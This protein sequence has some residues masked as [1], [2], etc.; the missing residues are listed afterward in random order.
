[1]NGHFL[2]LAIAA[3]A[4]FIALALLGEAW[5][6]LHRARR[7]K[8]QYALYA[9]RDALIRL[10]ASGAVDPQ[11]RAFQSTL[12]GVDAILHPRGPIGLEL[13]GLLRAK[14]SEGQHAERV[15]TLDADLD[16]LSP[17]QREALQQVRALIGRAM[18]DLLCHDSRLVRMMI[19][20]PNPAGN[21]SM[22]TAMVDERASLAIDGFIRSARGLIL[23]A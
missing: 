11:T 4:A 9:H 6:A 15:S 7:L 16:E 1:M 8:Y 5:R 21:G 20:A 18:V 12:A 17:P 10:G 19:W 23:A 14:H 22:G 2:N 13:Y 3:S